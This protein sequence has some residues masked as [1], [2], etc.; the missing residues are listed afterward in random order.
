MQIADPLV[1]ESKLLTTIHN[2]FR[3]FVVINVLQKSSQ[4][5]MNNVLSG[6]PGMLIVYGKDSVEHESRQATLKQFS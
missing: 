6:L 4:H 1:K 2:S 3:R 5:H